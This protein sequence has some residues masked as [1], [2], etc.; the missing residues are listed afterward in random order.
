[1]QW[2]S[3]YEALGELP[4]PRIVPP[5]DLPTVI[6]VLKGPPFEPLQSTSLRALSFKATLLLALA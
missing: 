3:F 5:W 6:R 4:P 1:M 2:S